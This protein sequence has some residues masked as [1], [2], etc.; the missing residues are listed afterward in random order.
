MNSL[1]QFFRWVLFLI[2]NGG[3]KPEYPFE[4]DG[5]EQPLE[6]R[7]GPWGSTQWC[8]PSDGALY[9]VKAV[10]DTVLIAESME[11]DIYGHTHQEAVD[12]AERRRREDYNYR[13]NYPPRVIRFLERVEPPL[14]PASGLRPHRVIL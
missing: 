4:D 10:D 8:D 13:C 2:R 9:G 5:V 14:E 7:I 3:R 11:R 1:R 12:E 6:F